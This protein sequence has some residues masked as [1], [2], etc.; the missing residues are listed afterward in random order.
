MSG[1]GLK[2]FDNPY[3]PEINLLNNAEIAE[4]G[5]HQYFEINGLQNKKLFDALGPH[6]NFSL[7]VLLTASVMDCT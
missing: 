5:N 4:L 1:W 7:K 6:N 3:V 2:K